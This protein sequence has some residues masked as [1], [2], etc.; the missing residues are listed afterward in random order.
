[1]RDKDASAKY[2][3]VDLSTN[4]VADGS[5]ASGYGTN[6]EIYKA[7]CPRHVPDDAY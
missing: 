6:F 7:L 4:E 3:I 2:R 1:M 5:S